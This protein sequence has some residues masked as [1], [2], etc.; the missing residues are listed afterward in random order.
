MVG[1]Q[2]SLNFRAVCL[3]PTT[4][5]D[6]ETSNFVE[7]YSIRLFYSSCLIC[8]HACTCV[9]GARGSNS[10]NRVLLTANLVPKL[11]LQQIRQHRAHLKPNLTPE[12]KGTNLISMMRDGNCTI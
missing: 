10:S 12:K 2:T 7:F 3:S 11:V 1:A 9:V 8:S 5:Y 6:H 4:V